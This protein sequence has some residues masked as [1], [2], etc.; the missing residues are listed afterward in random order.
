MWV[1][2][3]DWSIIQTWTI[4]ASCQR[5]LELKVARPSSQSVS[6]LIGQSN[7]I[8][9]LLTAGDQNK[10]CKALVKPISKAVTNE[11]S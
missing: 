9:I 6:I 1:T 5:E 10:G 4:S 8:L 11:S 2:V 7:A 3:W